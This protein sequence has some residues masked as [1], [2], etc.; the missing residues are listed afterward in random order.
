DPAAVEWAERVSRRVGRYCCL[1]AGAIAGN[2]VHGHNRNGLWRPQDWLE[3]AEGV[4]N[5]GLVPIWIGATYDEDYLKTHQLLRPGDI[6]LIGVCSIAMTVE[7][8]R[9]AKGVIAYQSGLGV[10]ASYL[11]TCAAM[12]WRPYGDSVDPHRFVSFHEGMASAWAPPDMLR[13]KRYFP[14]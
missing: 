13:E 14:A 4:R 7:L 12:F 1:F 6:S 5:R 9:R 11:G 3:V 2:T 10:I 8:L